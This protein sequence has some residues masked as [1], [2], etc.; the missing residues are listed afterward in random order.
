M[1]ALFCAMLLA[2]QTLAG[3]PDVDLE[4]VLQF[5][6]FKLE[7]IGRVRG[8]LLK[9]AA[10]KGLNGGI[11]DHDIQEFVRR[12]IRKRAA[13][14]FKRYDP[15]SYLPQYRDTV[16]NRVLEGVN[17]K[18]SDNHSSFI[19]PLVKNTMLYKVNSSSKYAFK[20]APFAKN[21]ILACTGNIVQVFD[22]NGHLKAEAL[23]SFQP[24]FMRAL[25]IPSTAGNKSRTFL[26]EIESSF[27]IANSVGDYKEFSFEVFEKKLT[28]KVNQTE[29][30]N[31]DGLPRISTD[32]SSLEYSIVEKAK[33]N[34]LH[35][36]TTNFTTSSA[37]YSP[38]L[39]SHVFGL[40]NGE[41]WFRQKYDN[42][43]IVVKVSDSPIIKLEENAKESTVI[44]GST[45]RIKKRGKAS[46][47]L[48]K[49]E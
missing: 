25:T 23:M 44:F 17:F 40:Q 39:S 31:S 24:Q 22:L 7:L 32:S 49:A 26:S 36:Q 29:G 41:V 27:F 8:D 47:A 3:V 46:E 10:P 38:A 30:K 13:V 11:A 34:R 48:R 20:V 2:W 18:L 35:P 43:E 9:L 16:K 28:E 1:W 19:K 45:I 14:I 15:Q 37:L 33:K 6:D 21:V 4:K 5:A 12:S 42:K